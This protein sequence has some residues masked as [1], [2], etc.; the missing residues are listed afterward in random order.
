MRSS[1]DTHVSVSNILEGLRSQLGR[2]RM[3]N[4]S[5]F[6]LTLLP[7]SIH[8]STHS[9]FS[10]SV[11]SIINGI[12]LIVLLRSN[13]RHPPVPELH[14]L[15]KSL[16]LFNGVAHIQYLPLVRSCQNLLQPQSHCHWSLHQNY[17][18]KLC[19]QIL[20]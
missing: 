1:T 4:A 12:F 10:R 7:T 15:P 14:L 17:I 2:A 8:Y 11:F 19:S 3:I 20:F 13:P 5:L 16:R 9:D 18:N 6:Q